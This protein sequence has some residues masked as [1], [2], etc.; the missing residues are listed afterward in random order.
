MGY[1]EADSNSRPGN[2]TRAHFC[3]CPT[4]LEPFILH[5]LSADIELYEASATDQEYLMENKD[6]FMLTSAL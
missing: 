5:W 6:S 3:T 2:D 4:L 1:A